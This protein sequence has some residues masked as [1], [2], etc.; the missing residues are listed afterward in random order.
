MKT[1][2]FLFVLLLI[3]SMSFAQAVRQPSGFAPPS[4]SGGGG[5]AEGT[6]VAADV[7]TGKTFSNDSAIGLSGSMPNNGAINIT[8]G[9]SSQPIL[10]GY[11]NGSGV[12]DGDAD[13]AGNNIASGVVIY[14]T[15][16]DFS[17]LA[18]VTGTLYRRV[19]LGATGTAG[20]MFIVRGDIYT[21]GQPTKTA[22]ADT[23]PPGVSYGAATSADGQYL[24][25]TSTTS[26]FLRTYK[27]SSINSRY[28]ATTAQDTNPPGASYGAAMS[29]DGQYLAVSSF[30]SPYLRTY[31]WSSVNNRYEVTTVQDVSPPG[32]AQGAVMSAD[33]QFLA[34]TS[35]STSPYL[36]TYKWSSVNNRYEMTV[37]Q[38][39][40]PPGASYYPAMSA[41][42]QYLAVTSSASPYLRTYKWSSIN[43][44]YEATTAQDTNPPGISYGSAMSADGQ[45]LAVT[46]SVSPYLR[47]YK[48]SSI[49]SRYEATTAQDTNPPGTSYGAAM[50][51]DGQFL[52]VS[53]LD[54][55][56]LQ[57]Y[58]WSSANNRY[59]VNTT[60]D[61]N[62]PAGAH[63]AT[64]SADG[65]Y[66]AVTSSTSSPYLATYITNMG[67][68]L[69]PAMP[70]VAS[71]GY[72][73]LPYNAAYIGALMESGVASDVVDFA[74]FWWRQDLLPPAE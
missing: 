55:P 43:S 53:S 2:L 35:P 57:T 20:D 29:A 69:T 15:R 68:R 51:A 49:N 9:T 7:L 25:V 23:N 33:G 6:A 38:D 17:P 52:A 39:T 5:D 66:L 31:K 63:C 46:S 18:S 21:V 19:E 1:R 64:T 13:L 37:T 44:R 47:T 56:Y 60:Q 26:P 3:C 42:G 67:E 12:V 73:L 74:A 4:T 45:Y 16:G 8:P 50:S 30:A 11:H 36:R 24:A 34:V 65:K 71:G 22:N 54:S 40:N 10:A 48:W 28:E 70:L 72:T 61:T 27:W 32:T 62:P 14:G 41:D 58:K 59:E